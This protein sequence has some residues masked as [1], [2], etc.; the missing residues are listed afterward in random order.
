MDNGEMEDCSITSVLF[1]FPDWAGAGASGLRSDPCVIRNSRF[2][3]RSQPRKNSDQSRHVAALPIQMSGSKLERQEA[4]AIA[5][6]HALNMRSGDGK[7]NL[8]SAP[9]QSHA[10]GSNH[11]PKPSQ[12]PALIIV[13][14]TQKHYYTRR[15]RAAFAQSDDSHNARALTEGPRVYHG[16]ANSWASLSVHLR[17]KVVPGRD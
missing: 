10:L 5:T 2:A 16:R 3:I 14:S 1:N 9:A 13:N 8:Y 17:G 12:R 6:Q 11:G 15:N 4:E 7:K